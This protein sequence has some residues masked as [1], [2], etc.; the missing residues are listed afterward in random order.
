MS[1]HRSKRPPPGR[2]A[3]SEHPHGLAFDPLTQQWMQGGAR[4][5]VGADAEFDLDHPFDGDK[6]EQREPAVRI[7]V[8]EAVKVALG[9]VVTARAP[10]MLSPIAPRA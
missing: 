10:K 9:P 3:P 2:R 5:K 6:I 7:V 4:R 1:E 8:N